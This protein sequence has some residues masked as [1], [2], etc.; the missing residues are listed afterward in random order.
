VHFSCTYTLQSYSELQKTVYIAANSSHSCLV[1][2]LSLEIAFTIFRVDF[3]EVRKW[4]TK[5]RDFPGFEKHVF[6]VFLHFA[7]SIADPIFQHTSLIKG[8][9]SMLLK[10]CKKKRL[11]DFL[12]PKIS[13]TNSH[14]P[15][16]VAQPL[17]S[18]Y[19][20][21]FFNIKIVLNT[22]INLLLE[23]HTTKTGIRIAD[24]QFRKQIWA[25]KTCRTRYVPY[26]LLTSTAFRAISQG[27]T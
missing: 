4:L 24:F 11:L 25:Q 20:A 15:S 14:H 26:Q 23:C 18:L 1:Q 19:I 2:A 7:S 5:T 22:E 12:G 16:F 27:G 13:R 10:N 17:Y 21:H 8:A 3:A 6:R 9:T